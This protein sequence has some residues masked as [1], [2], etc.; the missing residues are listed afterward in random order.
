MLMLNLVISAN[1]N[2]AVISRLRMNI[3]T[4]FLC[5]HI[6]FQGQYKS[7]NSVQDWEWGK[8]K[9]NGKKKKKYPKSKAY[10]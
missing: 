4:Y 1:I 6:F 7:T 9:R 8:E 10:E 3:N 2:Y 5:F